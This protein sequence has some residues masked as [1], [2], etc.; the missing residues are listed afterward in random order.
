MGYARFKSFGPFRKRASFMK[1]VLLVA[2]SNPRTAKIF[3]GTELLLQQI[4]DHAEDNRISL[5]FMYPENKTKKETWIIEV[6]KKIVLRFS[7]ENNDSQNILEFSKIITSFLLEQKIDCLHVFHQLSTPL[8]LIPV[9]NLLGIKTI[10]TIHDFIHICDSFN[11]INSNKDYCNIFSSEAHDCVECAIS[12]GV[13]PESLVRRRIA[14]KKILD[15][16]D[17]I[18]VGTEFS[19]KATSDFYNIDLNKF[20]IIP[21]TINS[22]RFPSNRTQPRSI[23][24][25]GNFTVPKGANLIDRLVRDSRLESY[26]FTQAGRVD[27]EFHNVVAHL[28]ENFNFKSLGKYD[29]GEVPDF[30]ASIAFFGSIWPETFCV[31]ATEAIEMGLKIVIPDIGAFRDRFLGE[32]NCFFYEP[33]NLDSAVTSILNA[34]STQIRITSKSDPGKNYSSQ[35]FELYASFETT[36]RKEFVEMD[37]N[38]LR[39]PLSFDWIFHDS[40]NNLAKSNS[41]NLARA[42][43]YLKANGFVETLKRLAREIPAK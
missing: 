26:S 7:T 10:Y 2:H 38:S 41:S 4:L 36:Q 13:D 32:N 1:N 16:S 40:P 8:V 35:V 17:L 5:F 20:K 28:S 15:N 12:R 3:G 6:N 19:G 29:L 18:T 43:N 9:S 30:S 21:P 42:K 39:L 24:F 11:L 27:A 31:A 23:L 25:L 14:Y 33:N 22:S 37:Y 34:E